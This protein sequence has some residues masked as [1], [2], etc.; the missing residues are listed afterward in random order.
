[1]KHYLLY[2]ASVY[3]IALVLLTTILIIALN[4]SGITLLPALIASA[5]IAAGHF[6]KREKRLPTPEEKVQL[7]WGSSAVA[8]IIGSLFVFFLVMLNP[9]AEQILQA[10]DQ[11]GIGLSAVIMLC[12]IAIH[13]AVFHVAYHWYAKRCLNRINISD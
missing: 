6:V 8:I 13:G 4:L 3:S 5:F 2:F 9:D 11:A 12:L 10:A 7:I 1:M